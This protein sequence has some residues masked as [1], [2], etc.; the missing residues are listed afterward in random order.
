MPG[1]RI[2]RPGTWWTGA[3]RVAIAA[4][5]RHV[6]RCELCVARRE[7]LSPAMV[8]GDH[9]SLGTLPAAAVEAIHRDPL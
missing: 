1:T 6:V 2:G 8:A 3:D 9:S 7:A 5:T 4:E